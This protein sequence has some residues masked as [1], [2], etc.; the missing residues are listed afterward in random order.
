MFPVGGKR[1]TVN[2]GTRFLSGLKYLWAI[3]LHLEFIIDVF[4]FITFDH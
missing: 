3:N 4:F 2:C 1:R